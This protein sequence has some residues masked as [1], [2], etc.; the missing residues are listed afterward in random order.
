MEPEPAVVKP[1]SVVRRLSQELIDR[2]VKI[3]YGIAHFEPR[4]SEKLLSLS[5]GIRI[6]YSHLFNCAGL[7]ADHIANHFGVA[8]VSRYCPLGSLWH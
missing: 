3:L 4:P 2:G 6:T 8:M 1:I 7:Q 5:N